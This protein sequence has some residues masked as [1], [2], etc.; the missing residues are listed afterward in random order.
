MIVTFVEAIEDKLKLINVVNL[1]L[2]LLILILYFNFV[3][4]ILWLIFYY[5]NNQGMVHIHFYLGHL[6]LLCKQNIQRSLLPNIFSWIH[7]PVI[8]PCVQINV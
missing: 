2:D 5:D 4:F 7:H 3:Q 8:L 1:E 6:N